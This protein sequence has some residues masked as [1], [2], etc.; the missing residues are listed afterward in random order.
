MSLGWRGKKE[1]D[2]H[3]AFFDKMFRTLKKQGKLN[4]DYI[5]LRN[6]SEILIKYSDN[7]RA[8]FHKLDS[9]TRDADTFQ[10]FLKATKEFGFDESIFM[11]NYTSILMYLILMNYANIE[12]MLLIILKGARYGNGKNE[13]VDGSET[14]TYLF[15]KIEK[16]YPNEQFPYDVIDTKF[17]NAIAHGWYFITHDGMVYFEDALMKK[18]KVLSVEHLLRKQIRLNI[19]GMAITHLVLAMDY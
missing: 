18:K 3:F 11:T 12:S 2:D 17:R 14:L 15:K 13:F 4:S 6:Q 1:F 9:V 19:L 16:L 7:C 8:G 5:N 10:K